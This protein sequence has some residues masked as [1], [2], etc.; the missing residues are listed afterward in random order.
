M[1]FEERN[2]VAVVGAG[3]HG[4]ATAGHL[5][6]AGVP[7][8]TFGDTFSFWRDYMPAGM[9]LRSAPRS[10]HIADPDGALTLDAWAARTGRQLSRPVPLADYIE[11]GRWFQSQAVPDVDPRRVANVAAENGGFRVTLDDGE[12]LQAARVVVAAGI[13][14]FPRIPDS[15]GALGPDLVSHSSAHTAF[16]G[17]AGRHV[18]V[19]GCGQSA[20]ESAALLSEAGAEVELIARAERPYFLG[21]R[22]A[23]FRKRDFWPPAPTDIGGRLTSWLSAAPALWR[24]LPGPFR[25]GISFRC[26][27][28]AGAGWLPARLTGVRMTMAS[29][30]ESAQGEGRQVLLRLTDGSERRTDHLLLATGYAIDVTRYEFLDRGLVARLRVV[31]GYPVLGRGL[32]SSVAGLHFVGA[33][34]AHS[35]GPVMRFVV[36]SW[37]AAPAVAA[38]VGGRRSAGRVW[39]FAPRHVL[40]AGAS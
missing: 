30:I 36:G 19:L 27:R 9:L 20:L 2:V 39:A 5:R 16:D 14:P 33:P 37:Y 34:A 4:L 26:I 8:R 25:P 15:L 32:E 23:A 21:S 40:T 1:N 28:P 11:Y 18:T 12:A 22:T 13:A 24:R 35:F 6:R 3:P 17:F 38:R 29:A 7:V 31:D 10:S